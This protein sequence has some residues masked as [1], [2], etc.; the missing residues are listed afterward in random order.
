MTKD[1]YIEN[2]SD[3]FRI[4]N[5]TSE[6]L[7]ANLIN[8]NIGIGTATPSAKL[9]VVGNIRATGLEYGNGLTRTESRDNAGLR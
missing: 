5:N 4:H 3:R 7:N 9:D 8:G 6:I 1:A 2:A